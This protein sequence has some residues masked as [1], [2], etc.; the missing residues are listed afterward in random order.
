MAAGT[1]MLDFGGILKSPVNRGRT[2]A[3]ERWGQVFY[4]SS[5]N[6]TT[7]TTDQSKN[8]LPNSIFFLLIKLSPFFM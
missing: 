8:K 4:F 7:A 6:S 5:V 3:Q 1:S 2:M